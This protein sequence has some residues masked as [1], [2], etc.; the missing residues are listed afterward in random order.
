MDVLLTQIRDG[1]IQQ[2]KIWECVNECLAAFKQEAYPHLDTIQKL[3]PRYN[4]VVSEIQKNCN[5]IEQASDME[6]LKYEVIQI[7]NM[8]VSLFQI[9]TYKSTD[10]DKEVFINSLVGHM[11]FQ[12][13]EDQQNQV[14][15]STI[16][17]L[18]FCN[19]FVKQLR[20][21]CAF[22]TQEI[23]PTTELRILLLELQKYCE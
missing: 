13:Q 5:D 9:G 20:L 3:I 12:V 21:L 16:L 15:T 17:A 18:H 10:W 4:F 6:Y 11:Q 14:A 19:T 23:D 22:Q 7:T 1:N 8:F 2:G